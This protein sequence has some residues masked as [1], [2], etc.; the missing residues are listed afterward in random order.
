MNLIEEE[1]QKYQIEESDEQIAVMSKE[2][3]KTSVNS[4]I[5]AHARNYLKDKAKNHTKSEMIAKDKFEKK[6]YFSDRR[7]TKDEVQLLFCLRTRMLECKNNFKMQYQNLHCR[8]C[9]DPNSLDDEDHI[10]T[11]SALSM[12]KSDIKFSDVFGD[13]EQQYR[14]VKIF[15][16]AMTKR[17]FLLEKL[18]K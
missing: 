17:N 1:R 18:D 3:F 7:F 10:L 8:I 15:K 6:K 5:E 9:N 12:A 13:T 4:K 11:C 16:K 14:A 2:C